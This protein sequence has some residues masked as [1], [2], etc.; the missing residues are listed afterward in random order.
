MENM[1]IL[2][3]NQYEL[4]H[5]IIEKHNLN[6]SELDDYNIIDMMQSMYDDKREGSIYIIVE[7]NLIYHQLSG[8]VCIYAQG[9]IKEIEKYPEDFDYPTAIYKYKWANG[10]FIAT[11]MGDT[12]E[13][14]KRWADGDEDWVENANIEISIKIDGWCLKGILHDIASLISEK[15]PRVSYDCEFKELKKYNR[16]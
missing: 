8:D 5:K 13:V 1:E 6:I 11:N 16:D 14:Y 7:R 12:K 10:V 3:N 4:I 2:A 15:Y 9:E